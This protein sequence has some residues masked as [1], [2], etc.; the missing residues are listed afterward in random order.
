ME[1]NQSS[2]EM[3][4]TNA[5]LTNL[6][7]THASTEHAAKTEGSPFFRLDPG[8]AIWTWIVFFLLLGVLGKFAWKP[9]LKYLDDRESFIRSSLENAEKAQ[10]EL[11]DIIEKQKKM[12]SETQEQAG[13]II[14]E[15]KAEASSLADE[16]RAGARSEAKMI[17]ENARR[18]VEQQKLAAMRDVREETVNL[19]LLLTGK[20]LGE[21]LDPAAQKKIVEKHLQ[22]ISNN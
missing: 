21:N 9:I 7:E 1:T 13:K 5:K 10:K 19:T 11:Q 15:A 20:L 18:D 14:Q 16:I 22:T 8:L 4:S 12:I 2:H 6:V 3:S 17:L